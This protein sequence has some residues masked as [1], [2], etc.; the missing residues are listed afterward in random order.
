MTPLFSPKLILGV[1]LTVANPNVAA[2]PQASVAV[3]ADGAD[4]YQDTPPPSTFDRYGGLPGAAPAQSQEHQ[5]LLMQLVRTIV[6]LFGVLCLIYAT[7]KFIGPK[8]LA[9][10]GSKKSSAMQV[11]DRLSLDGR[12]TLVKVELSEG[13]HYLLACGDHGATLIDKVTAT[14]AQGS[15]QASSFA[16]HIGASTAPKE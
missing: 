12:T 10:I 7:A 16:E 2:S 1:L 3:R 8:L 13:G 4:I 5:G 9:G 15:T 14:L 11:T 6:A